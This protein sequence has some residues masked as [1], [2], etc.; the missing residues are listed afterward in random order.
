MFARLVVSPLIPRIMNEFQV[1]KGTI[2]LALSGMWFAYAMLQLPGG[3]LAN[4]YGEKRLVLTGLAILTVSA[5]GVM[6]A[7]TFSL[8]VI[9][10]ILVGAGPGLYFP[11]AT[12]IISDQFEAQ[13]S[14][15]LGLH[16]SGGDTAGL[17]AP[18]AAT[19]FAFSLGWRTSFIVPILIAVPV[20]VAVVLHIKPVSTTASHPKSSSLSRLP[21][22]LREP[23]ITSSIL[24]AGMLAFSFQAIVSFFPTFLIEYHELD[25]EYANKLFSLMFLVWILGL[26]LFGR[27][28]DRFSLDA[29]LSGILI[30]FSVGVSVLLFGPAEVVVGGVVL[31]GVGMSWGG[32][33]G[34]RIID[35][36]P[37]GDRSVGYGLVRTIYLSIGAFGSVVTGFLASQIGWTTAYGGLAVVEAI[38]GLVL[39]VTVTKWR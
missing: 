18:I 20:S 36:L 6:M 9:A 27:V 22:L 39:L 17:V 32:I 35:G 23:S 11:A 25:S 26:P 7:Q 8:F 2:G 4:R 10:L 29:V 21:N 16:I 19:Y 38:V 3:V 30:M 28:A 31:V 12:T 33:I 37:I 34:S 13:P 14:Q 24:L 15:A 5:I 1:T